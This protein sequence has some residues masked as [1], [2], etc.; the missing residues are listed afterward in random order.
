MFRK[1][2]ILILLLIL[3]GVAVPAAWYHYKLWSWKQPIVVAV[4]PIAGDDHPAT[5]R[6]IAELRA[7]DFIPVEQF[8]SREASRYGFHLLRPI[9]MQLREPVE[10][11]PPEPPKDRSVFNMVEWS[12]RFRWWA[13]RQAPQYGVEPADL[14]L[15]LVYRT[16]VKAVEYSH[17]YALR[18]TRAGVVKA[19]AGRK[20]RGRNQVVLVHELLHLFGASDK[21][22]LASNLP[23]Y[24]QGYADPGQ[25]PLYPQH[26]AEIMAGRMPLGPQRAVMAEHLGRV[27]IGSFT[28]VEIGWQEDP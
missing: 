24:P 9:R 25:E 21:Y 10:S 12:L 6:H 22:D 3:L 20:W 18:K 13:S 11:L 17:S 5:A 27:M 19:F 26:M 8:F 28:A 23:L 4:I 14:T 1:L 7:D 2:R 15:F 16:P